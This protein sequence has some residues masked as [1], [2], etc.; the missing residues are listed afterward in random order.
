MRRLGL[1]HSV[2]PFGRVKID[3]RPFRSAQFTRPHEYQWCKAQ[4]TLHS[5]RAFVAV[6]SSED[7]SN[8]FRVGRSR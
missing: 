1:G 4:G 5:K 3:I 2:P 7:G 6:Y 8:L